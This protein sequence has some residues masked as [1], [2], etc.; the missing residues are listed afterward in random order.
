MK[1]IVEIFMRGGSAK[2]Q[3]TEKYR[4]VGGGCSKENVDLLRANVGE[5][6]EMSISRHLQ[7]GD[8]SES[9]KWHFYKSSKSI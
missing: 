4:Q 2:G 8:I 6:P 5:E 7:K 3:R 1:Q 9:T